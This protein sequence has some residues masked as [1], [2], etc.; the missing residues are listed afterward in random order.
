[1]TDPCTGQKPGIT[2]KTVKLRL[3]PRQ[4]RGFPIKMWMSA[5][6]IP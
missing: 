2:P 5:L 6:M 3:S 4:S 1:M